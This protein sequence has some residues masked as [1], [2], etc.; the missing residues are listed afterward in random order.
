MMREEGDCGRDTHYWARP[1]QNRTGRSCIRLSPRMFDGWPRPSVRAPASVTRFPGTVSGTCGIGSRS[2]W[3]PE[4]STGV[5]VRRSLARWN[6]ELHRGGPPIRYSF[7]VVC[8]AVALGAALALQYYGFRTVELPAFDLAIVVVTWYAGVG[9]SVLAVVLSCGLL[10]LLLHRAFL[11]LPN[12][13][14]RPTVLFSFRGLG[15][16]NCLVRSC[17]APHRERSSR[18]SRPPSGRVG[19]A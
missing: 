1:A 9:P 11:H 15:G 8:V 17:S 7:S 14:R 4:G 2:P 18:H 12:F 19:P 13:Q 16:D 10:R 6:L 3:P 5:A